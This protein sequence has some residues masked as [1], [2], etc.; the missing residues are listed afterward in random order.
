VRARHILRTVARGA[1][2][3]EVAR[4]RGE[5]LAASE[6]IAKGEPFEQVTAEVSQDPGSQ[7]RGGDLGFFARGQMVK[8]FEDAAF[9]LT[10]GQM[11][12]PVK[13]EFGFH[14]I[15]LEER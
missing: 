8:E 15:K 12:G 10:P 11:S 1:S 6:R 13:T 4:V 9:A 2:D 7:I 5:T 14:L 3:E